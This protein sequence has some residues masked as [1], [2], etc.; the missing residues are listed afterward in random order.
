METRW[1]HE[2]SIEY[3]I[4]SAYAH[5]KG[6]WFNVMFGWKATHNHKCKV[7]LSHKDWRKV[8]EMIR[9]Y[10]TFCKGEN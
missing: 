5:G 8:D 4:A 10:Y 3:V 2:D 7:V 6:Y 1:I 9:Y